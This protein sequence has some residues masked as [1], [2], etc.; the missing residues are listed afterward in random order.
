MKHTES[1]FVRNRILIASALAAV[2]SPFSLVL[3]GIAAVGALVINPFNFG[4]AGAAYPAIGGSTKTQILTNSPEGEE[5]KWEQ[6]VIQA[7]AQNSPFADNMTGPMGSGKP[8]TSMGLT[9]T[10]AG[11]S[12]VISTVDSF[13]APGVQGNGVRVGLEEQ[14]K[15]GDFL[16]KTSLWW[17][18]AGIDNTGLTQTIIG[19]SWS[20]LSKQL[21]ARNLARKQSNDAMYALRNG[22]FSG[23]NPLPNVVYPNG[24]TIDTLGT[25]D[26]YSTSLIVA[27]SGRLK[28]NG[29]IPMNVRPNPDVSTSMPPPIQKYMQFTTDANARPIMTESAYLEGIMQAQNRGDSNPLFTGEYQTWNNNIIYPWVTVIHGGYGPVGAP[30]QPEALLGT[31]IAVG[32]SVLTTMDGGGSNVAAAALPF[33]DYFE[34]FSR[35]TYTPINGV[36]SQLTPRATYGYIAVVHA[37]GADV[38]KVSL[39]RYTTN[40]ASVG[41]TTANQLSG[42]KRLGSASTNDSLTTIGDMTWNSGPWLVAGDNGGYL[43]VSEAIIPVGSKIYEVNSK[44]VPIAYGFGLGEMALVCGY[45]MVPVPASN[46]ASFKTAAMRTE[47][48]A[49]HGQAFAEGIQVAYGVAPFLRPDGLGQNFV[50]EIFARKIPGMPIIP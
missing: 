30:I 6:S 1:A 35:F 19:Q 49:P 46:G 27:G 43:G 10:V 48:M 45:G 37:S 21:I 14:I 17:C 26:T 5:T 9:K 31:A 3:A 23:V 12:I 16:L 41:I 39:F 2:A 24:K 20:P 47:Y 15:P 29:A 8:V 11:Q 4:Y 28:D 22:S 13:G 50:T 34:A 7:S 18:G 32:G 42:L 25:S 40:T 44:G 36:T 33:R 38:G